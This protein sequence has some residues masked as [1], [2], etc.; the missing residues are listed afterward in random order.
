MHRSSLIDKAYS[1]REM[2]S[3]FVQVN[4]DNEL[5]EPEDDNDCSTELTFDEFFEMLARMY[6]AREW[7][8]RSCFARG[9]DQWVET[10]L[11][12]KARRII[13]AQQK[14]K[15]KGFTATARKVLVSNQ[16]AKSQ[17]QK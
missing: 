13:A 9:F 5:F 1:I 15:S 14:A 3:N 16:L 7:N 11:A 2:V 4:I 10:V 12:P 8:W 17:E 6:A